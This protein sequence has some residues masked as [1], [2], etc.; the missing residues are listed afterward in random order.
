MRHVLRVAALLAASLPISLRA[1]TLDED[2]QQAVND[3]NSGKFRDVVNRLAPLADQ[4]G[5]SKT[6]A[7]ILKYLAAAEW[8]TRKR[9]RTNDLIRRALTAD[10]ELELDPSGFP[11]PLVEVFNGIRGNLRG[12]LLVTCTPPAGEVEVVGQALGRCGIALSVRIGRHAVR[13]RWGQTTLRGALSVVVPVA[14]TVTLDARAPVETTPPDPPPPDVGVRKRVVRPTPRTSN[15]RLGWTLVVGGTAAAIAGTA[16]QIVAHNTAQIPRNQPS[17]PTVTEAQSLEQSM[18]R[19]DLI[20][21]LL[22]GVGGTAIATG[23]I[24]LILDRKRTAASHSTGLRVTLVRDA[25]G[26]AVPSL[27]RAWSF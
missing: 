21:G 27:A 19:E 14:Q 17:S 8:V 12:K 24:T 13:V 16:L 22:I 23:I 25:S 20:G 1:A 11:L 2:L 9:D 4:V 3:F 15:K 26:A 18:K 10:P 7:A 6:R 5:E